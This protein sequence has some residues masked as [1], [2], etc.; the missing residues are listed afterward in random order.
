MR[1]ATSSEAFREHTE[2]GTAARQRQ[3]VLDCIRDS[4][5]PLNNRQ[6]SQI[7]RIPINAVSGRV[8]ELLQ[9]GLVRKVQGHHRDPVTHKTV[10]FIEAVTPAPVQRR[11]EFPS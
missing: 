4:A 9:A 3:A 2:T 1:A 11:F 5:V 6:I 10:R 8:F 7:S